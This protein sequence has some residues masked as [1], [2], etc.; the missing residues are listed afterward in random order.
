MYLHITHTHTHTHTQVK[1]FLS[2]Q[3]AKQSLQVNP[4]IVAKTSMLNSDPALYQLYKDLVG[5]GLITA[6]EFWTNRFNEKNMTSVKGKKIGGPSDKQESGLPS[7]FLV[8]KS[9]VE[10]QVLS[11]L[12]F[13][14]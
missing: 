10:I 11:G 8:G 9:N 5:S 12:F 4:E 7:A 14:G 13:S 2:K 6:E 3:L 1:E